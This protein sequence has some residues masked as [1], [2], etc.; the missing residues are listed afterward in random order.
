MDAVLLHRRPVVWRVRR[1]DGS[2]TRKY[3]VESGLSAYILTCQRK[4]RGARRV[5]GTRSI[6]QGRSN[7]RSVSYRGG[8]GFGGLNVVGHL[9]GREAVVQWHLTFI[10]VK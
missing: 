1:H 6:K 10:K 2:L 5:A 7:N 9:Y 4:D 8:G 3:V